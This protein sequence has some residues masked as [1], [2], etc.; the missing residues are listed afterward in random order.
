MKHGLIARYPKLENHAWCGNT[1]FPLTPFSLK[2]K[3]VLLLRKVIE[4][5]FGTKK[6]VL[7]V[8][9]LDNADTAYFDAIGRVGH[10]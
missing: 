6:N 9:L 1:H 3:A 5:S 2:F 8:E 10:S 4:L 7:L